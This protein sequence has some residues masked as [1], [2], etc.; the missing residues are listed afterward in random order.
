V[1]QKNAFLYTDG[2]V[3]AILQKITGCTKPMVKFISTVIP[4]WWSISGRY[5]FTNLARYC[6]YCEQSI[7]NAFERGFDFFQFNFLLME[8]HLSEEKILAFDPSYI[9]KSGKRTPGLG[10]Y[11]SGTAQQALK[12]LEIGELACV[13]VKSGNAFHLEAIQTP[14]TAE[15]N[16][17]SIVKHYA[18]SL[19]AKMPELLALSHYLVTDGYFMKKE[20]ITPM[21]QAGMHVITKMRSDANLCYAVRE[22]DQPQGRGRKR[23]KG[24]KINLK[25]IDKRRWQKIS[26]QDD[27]EIYSA[28]VYCVTLKQRVRVVYILD[29]RTQK[30]EVFLATDVDLSGTKILEYYRLRFQI[31]FL[32]RDAKQHAGLEDCQARSTNKLHTHF[33]ISLTSVSIAKVC[34]HLSVPEPERGAF[35]LQSIKRLYH[36]KLLTE[37]IFDNLDL[38]LNCRKIKRLYEQCLDFGRMAA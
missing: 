10:R 2:V 11:W 23:I 14:G 26:D 36:N 9:Y 28:I 32:L 24:Q 17:K 20:F 22:Q 3:V 12:G 8:S 18:D 1:R 25:K 16:G 19:L 31:E 34:H 29:R 5:N 13:D 30:Y 15:R 7:R 27:I 4:L 21:Q 38:D 35:S 6:H 33:N 37:T